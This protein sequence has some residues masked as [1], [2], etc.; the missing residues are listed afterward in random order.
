[1]DHEPTQGPDWG[2]PSIGANMERKMGTLEGIV[3][4]AF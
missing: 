3:C 1:M 2:V 4:A